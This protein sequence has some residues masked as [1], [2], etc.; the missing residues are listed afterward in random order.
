MLFLFSKLYI[1]FLDAIYSVIWNKICAN[2]KNRTVKYILFSQKPYILLY[3]T[4]SEL[5]YKAE[6]W[7]SWIWEEGLL[8]YFEASFQ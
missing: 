3:E 7:N 4:K 2:L 1:I 6:Q 8:A 5:I